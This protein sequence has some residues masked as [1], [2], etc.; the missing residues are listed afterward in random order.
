MRER[1]VEKEDIRSSSADGPDGIG[2]GR[3]PSWIELDHICPGSSEETSDRKPHTN[4]VIG[5]ADKESLKR[6]A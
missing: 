4:V 6:G 3:P 1:E 5:H 2:S